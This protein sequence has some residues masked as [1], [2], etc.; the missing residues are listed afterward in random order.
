[1]GGAGGARQ[2]GLR[3]VC[4][5]AFLL[6]PTLIERLEDWSK[7]AFT[8]NDRSATDTM[9]FGATDH[10]ARAAIALGLAPEIAIQCVTLNP[11]RHMRIDAWVGSLTPGL[12]ADIVLLEDVRTLKVAVVY[13]DG[14]QAAEGNAYV[15]PLPKC[16]WPTWATDTIRIDRELAAADFR[17]AAAMDARRCGP[18]C[19]VPFIG[20]RSSWCTRW[21]CVMVRSSAMRRVD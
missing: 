21:R 4:G 6:L 12:F 11:A 7:I 1:V 15:G 9:K 8:T 3:A 14:A 20:T 16:G 13:A 10:K 2:A 5:D 17:I 18:L 19:C